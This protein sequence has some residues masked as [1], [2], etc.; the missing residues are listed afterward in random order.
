[1]KKKTNNSKRPLAIFDIDGTIFRSSLLIEFV[2]A[3]IRHGLFKPA[4]A[5]SYQRKERDWLDRQGSYEDYVA[6]VV[7]AFVR[8][9]KGVARRDFLRISREVTARH[10]NRVYRF[11]RDLVKNLKRRGYYLVAISHSPREI[12]DQFAKGLGFDKVYGIVYELDGR[13]QFSGQIRY[14]EF[15]LDKAKVVRRVLDKEPAT[16]RRS[17]GV[18][19]TESD[20]PFLKLVEQPICFNPNQKLFAAAKRR[21][22]PVVVERKDVVYRM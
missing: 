3:A 19:D 6:S 18:G 5:R 14:R 8:N 2:H 17:V 21:H 16:L 1:M 7:G 20:I 11:T 4:V 9:L 15:I 13:R 22:W 10:R 12:V